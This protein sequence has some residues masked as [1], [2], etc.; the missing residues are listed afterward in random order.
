M[1]SHRMTRRHG[2][3]AV[4]GISLAIGLATVLG[5]SPAAGADPDPS[6][7][8]VW[9]FDDY[10]VG[11]V[12]VGAPTDVESYL[13][14]LGTTEDQAFTDFFIPGSGDYSA[15]VDDFDIPKVV[16]NIYEQVFDSAGPTP[17]DGSF[18]DSIQALWGPFPSIT[19]GVPY[20]DNSFVDFRGFGIGDELNVIPLFFSNDFV[21]DSAG[22]EDQVTF[23]AQTL[24]LFDFAAPDAA[25]G[26][27][28]LTQ[29]LAEIGT[30]F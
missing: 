13:H 2:G 10:D 30:A 18:S 20:F 25:A 23:F 16:D 9:P 22:I 5:D 1:Q 8:D 28:D 11:A 3:V 29:L 4:L 7:I 26:A 15:H 21:M 24:T 6:P 17:V 27:S 19:G 12:P 14:G